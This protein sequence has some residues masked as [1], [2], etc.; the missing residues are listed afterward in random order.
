MEMIAQ[1]AEAKIFL[2]AEGILKERVA[3]SYRHV[4]IDSGL[5][6]T[7]TRREAK[8]LETLSKLGFPS[9]KLVSMD[10]ANGKI[11]MEQING[12]KLRDVILSDPAGFGCKVGEVIGGL[13]NIGIVHGDPT[14]SN[15]IISSGK[16]HLIDFGLSQFS[17]KVEDKAVDLHLFDRAVES[18]HHT[19]YSKVMPAFFEGYSNS[20]KD[21]AVVLERLEA[22]KNRGRNKNKGS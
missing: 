22:V 5:R 11:L 2:T 9:P 14:T 18:A 7:R 6:G 20:C 8:I 3:K 21:S 16:V 12:D 13:H 19:I 15:M 17:T 10:D 1:G 4:L